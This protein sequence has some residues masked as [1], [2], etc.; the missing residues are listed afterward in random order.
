MNPSWREIFDGS[1]VNSLQCVTFCHENKSVVLACLPVVLSELAG[2]SD[3]SNMFKLVDKYGGRKIYL[4]KN[5]EGF[6][7]LCNVYLEENNYQH[8]RRLAKLNGQIEVSSKWGVFLALRRAA[9]HLALKDG[10]N[11]E[12]II[13]SFG[14]TQRQLRT[15]RGRFNYPCPP[16]LP[17]DEKYE[18][19]RT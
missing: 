15:L 19:K 7:R 12:D 1:A 6:F 13:S 14:I 10:I 3:F 11:N 5:A 9:I 18:K 2:V 8:W 16:F 4:P 17:Q